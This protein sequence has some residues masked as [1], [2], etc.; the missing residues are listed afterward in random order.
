MLVA[1]T[2]TLLMACIA[3]RDTRGQCSRGIRIFIWATYSVPVLAM[4]LAILVVLLLRR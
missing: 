4:W 1:L 3:W 2:V